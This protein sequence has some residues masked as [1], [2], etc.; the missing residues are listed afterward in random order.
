MIASSRRPRPRRGTRAHAAA[1]R[2]Q[3][4]GRS[5]S[6]GDHQ[7]ALRQ[8]AS[9]ATRFAQ[10]T[11]G[12]NRGFQSAGG[13]RIPAGSRPGPRRL[14]VGQPAP[15]AFEPC[16]SPLSERAMD[17]EASGNIRVPYEPKV[18]LTQSDLYPQVDPAL[19][20]GRGQ[21]SGSSDAISSAATQEA[22]A[23]TAQRGAT[24]S[25]VSGLADPVIALSSAS[26]I[27]VGRSLRSRTRRCR[28]PPAHSRVIDRGY[29]QVQSPA[30]GRGTLGICADG[31][32]G[33]DFLVGDYL[34]RRHPHRQPPDR[35]TPVDAA[36]GPR[37][38]AYAVGSR[39]CP[40]KSRSG[41]AAAASRGG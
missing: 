30:R 20:A 39:G 2:T 5:R 41:A 11:V 24:P 13:L 21:Q 10:Y 8:H 40:W 9:P 14:D 29:P 7:P 34:E 26:Q 1:R 38:V 3:D 37:L 4:R 25:G 12:P 15:L 35:G 27:S 36:V 18:E 28:P 31:G 32:W 19:L 33:C 22:P 16:R 6:A 23:L 17:A